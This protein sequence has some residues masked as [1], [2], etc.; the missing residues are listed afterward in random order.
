MT[1]NPFATNTFSVIG[2]PS[3]P[4]LSAV[5]QNL[6]TFA[7]VSSDIEGRTI[8]GA[9]N[10][11][12]GWGDMRAEYFT[13]Y[14]LNSMSTF[15][16]TATIEPSGTGDGR[17]IGYGLYLRDGSGKN[18]WFGTRDL[19]STGGNMG[20]LTY[21]TDSFGGVADDGTGT[22]TNAHLIRSF[23]IRQD[24]TTRYF[25]Y[26]YGLNGQGPWTSWS[27]KTRTHFLIPFQVGWFG[28]FSSNGGNVKLRYFRVSS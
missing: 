27:T 18:H 2:S 19:G 12:S 22:P 17:V 9:V 6:T 7:T 13:N 15:S 11:T 21:T 1:Y 25:D 8:T 5:P 20:T 28:Y 16:I 3:Q 24:A 14:A 4:T 26:S 10:S 23:R